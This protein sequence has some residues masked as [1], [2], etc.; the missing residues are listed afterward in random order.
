MRRSAGN[1]ASPGAFATVVEGQTDPLPETQVTD[2]SS[3]MPDSPGEY[4]P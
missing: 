2:L 3:S 1:V 4:N